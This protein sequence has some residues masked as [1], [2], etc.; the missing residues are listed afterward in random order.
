[1]N[2]RKKMTVRQIIDLVFNSKKYAVIQSDE[3]TRKE[4]LSFFNAIKNKTK[5]FNVIDNGSHLLIWE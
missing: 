2:D 1:M 5:I 3:T 4:T